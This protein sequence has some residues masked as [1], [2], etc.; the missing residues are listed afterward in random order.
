[1]KKI[2]LALSLIV[3]SAQATNIGGGC[4]NVL[5]FAGSPAKVTHWKY[6]PLSSH[7]LTAAEVSGG[8]SGKVEPGDTIEIDMG[9][10]CPS[11]N[12]SNPISGTIVKNPSTGRATDSAPISCQDFPKS[13]KSAH[14]AA[15]VDCNDGDPLKA[16]ALRFS[17]S[18]FRDCGNPA[19]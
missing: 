16:P 11:L 8:Y 7:V 2:L 1:M 10:N 12:I 3:M 15:T 6:S 5:R 19:P 14:F 17:L 4:T 13:K 9:T 18:S